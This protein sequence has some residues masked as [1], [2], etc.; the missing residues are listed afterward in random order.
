MDFKELTA[1]EIEDMVKDKIYY[2]VRDG[3]TT[4]S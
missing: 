1:K 4:K 3:I 2:P